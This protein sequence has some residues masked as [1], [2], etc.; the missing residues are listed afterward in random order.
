MF[1]VYKV[2]RALPFMPNAKPWFAVSV[3]AVVIAVA[4]LA[5]RGLN[6]GIDF[7]GGTVIEVTYPDPIEVNTV[8]EKLASVDMGDAIVQN[9]GTAHD[10]LI[11]VPV[12]PEVTSAQLSEVVLKALREREPKVEMKRV[13]YVGPQVGAELLYDG[14]LALIVVTLGI[15]GY[16][17]VRFEWK[18]AVGAI[19]ATAHDVLII[20]GLFAIFQ[21]NFDL[22]ALAAILAVLGYSVNDTVVVF[23]RIRENFRKMRRATVP[24]IMDDAITATLSR[25]ILTGGSTMLM[26]GAMLFFGGDVLYFFALALTIG[27]VVGIYSSIFVA[28]AVTMWLGISREDFIK[29]DKKPQ[30]VQA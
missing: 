19:A 24:E 26:V 13:E 28:S 20:F 12:K 1:E 25:T 9:F 23:D 7:T 30:D 14:L 15:M 6:L 11:R 2:T 4:G 16:L 29:P 27:I 3:I 18:F 5:L 10:V 8:R 17:A 21:W 22:T